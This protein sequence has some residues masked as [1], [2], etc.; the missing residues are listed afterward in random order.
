MIEM[1]VVAVRI[2]LPGNSPVVILREIVDPERLLPI[3]IG[4][5]EATAI[6][7]ALDGVVTPRPMTHDLLCDVLEELGAKLTS[8]E[9]TGVQAGTYYADLVLQFASEERR[10]SSRPSDAM[11]LALRLDAPIFVSHTLVDEAGIL[12]DD[13]DELDE[14]PG[15]GGDVVEQFK[16]FIDTVNP[17]DFGA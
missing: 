14:T 15:Q 16:D 7:F 10:I 9:I 1:E 17:E 12:A 3:F 2:E 11:A 13:D 6:A 8:V 4:Q 5:P